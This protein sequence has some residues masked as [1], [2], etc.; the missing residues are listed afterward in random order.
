MIQQGRGQVFKLK[1]KGR[2]GTRCGL[3]RDGQSRNED[4]ASSGGSTS[5]PAGRVNG[6]RPFGEAAARRVLL[7]GCRRWVGVR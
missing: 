1:T 6:C 2:T 5:T 3:N 4:R 7:G